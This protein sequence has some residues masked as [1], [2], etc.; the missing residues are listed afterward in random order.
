[1]QV[2]QN[3]TPFIPAQKYKGSNIRQVKEAYQAVVLVV[4]SSMIL[5]LKDQQVYWSSRECGL[6]REPNTTFFGVVNS[7]GPCHAIEQ[8]H[9]QQASNSTKLMIESSEY[10]V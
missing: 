7:S 3:S 8:F 1:M 5:W 6:D 9:H 2:K 4:P 10:D